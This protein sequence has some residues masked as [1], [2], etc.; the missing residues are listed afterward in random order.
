MIWFEPPAILQE[1]Y[2]D[3]CNLKGEVPVAFANAA[4]LQRLILNNNPLGNPGAGRI[5]GVP[6]ALPPALQRLE[7][8]T[9]GLSGQVRPGIAGV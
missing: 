7:L 8:K 4:S 5:V 3:N 2:L 6:T 1:L 9:C